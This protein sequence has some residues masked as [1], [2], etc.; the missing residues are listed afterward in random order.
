M[1]EQNKMLVCEAC[2]KKLGNLPMKEMSML[3]TYG[4]CAVCGKMKQCWEVEV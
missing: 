3:K 1:E 2:K 4:K